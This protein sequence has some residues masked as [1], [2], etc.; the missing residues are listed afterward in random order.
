VAPALRRPLFIVKSRHELSQLGKP[1][2]IARQVGAAK[3]SPAT[4]DGANHTFAILSR[5]EKCAS[6]GK[7]RGLQAKQYIGPV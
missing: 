4:M 1:N 6:R 5:L 3:S 2:K 7:K